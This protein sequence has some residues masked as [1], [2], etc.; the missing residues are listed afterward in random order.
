MSDSK[1]GL[2]GLGSHGPA[3]ADVR[4]RLAALPLDQLPEP[5]PS[6]PPVV[7]TSRVATRTVSTPHGS[8]RHW[9]AR[10]GRSS[11]TRA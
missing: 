9:S 3:V 10:C 8:T 2:L 5:P 11:S 4:A 6:A 1:Y 7:T